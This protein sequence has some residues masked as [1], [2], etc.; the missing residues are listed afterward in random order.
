MQHCSGQ[1]AVS[2]VRSCSAKQ[3]HSMQCVTALIPMEVGSSYRRA[4]TQQNA[5][6][7]GS[8]QHAVLTVQCCSA[9][10]DQKQVVCPC[11]YTYGDLLFIQVCRDPAPM[12]CSKVQG[13]MQSSL[14]SAALQNRITA[15]SVSL[16]FH[17]C[18]FALQ[19]SAQ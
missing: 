18:R 16:R 7:Q 5:L 15:G 13:K 8:G 19:T 11:T 17:L 6:Q 10:Q 9:K 14:F 1:N 12:H 3:A 4:V 2:T